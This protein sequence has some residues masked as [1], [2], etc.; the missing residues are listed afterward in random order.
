MSQ[1]SNAG[2]TTG[3]INDLNKNQSIFYRNYATCQEYPY[4]MVGPEV[5]TREVQFLDF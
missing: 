5:K 3:T 2:C 1:C 4:K